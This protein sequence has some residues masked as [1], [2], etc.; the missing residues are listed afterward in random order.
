[1]YLTNAGKSIFS[2]EYLL[3]ALF[4]NP[5]LLLVFLTFQLISDQF[6]LID[7]WGF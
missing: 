7:L 1:M 2:G 5:H 6:K 3:G 4:V